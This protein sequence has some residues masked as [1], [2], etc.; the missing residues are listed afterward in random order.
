MIEYLKQLFQEDPYWEEV[1]S[2]KQKEKDIPQEQYVRIWNEA[3]MP[4]MTKLLRQPGL[5]NR[6]QNKQHLTSLFAMFDR[7]LETRYETAF[8][9]Y[10]YTMEWFLNNPKLLKQAQPYMS[11]KLNSAYEAYLRQF[12]DPEAAAERTLAFLMFSITKLFDK[13]PPLEN[14]F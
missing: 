4:G 10:G 8:F 12:E 7:M 9:V 2:E 14:S 11:E 5:F 13:F 1:I 6:Q 3:V